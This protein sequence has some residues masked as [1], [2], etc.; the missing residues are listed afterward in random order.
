MT[1]VKHRTQRLWSPRKRLSPTRIRT[2]DGHLVTI[3]NGELANK[4]IQN[5]GKRPYIRRIMN[6]TITYDTPPEKVRRA[7]EIVKEILADHE[8]MK[9]EMPPRVFFNDFNDASLNIFAIYWY[10][11]PDWWAFCAF[12]ERVNHELLQRFNDEKIDFAFPTQTLHLA[13]DP[14]RPLTVG[15]QNK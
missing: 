15:I 11:P 4:T 3:P 2:L 6:I 8:G 7:V 10:H 9:P 12:G 5:I 13:G 1:H 14:N